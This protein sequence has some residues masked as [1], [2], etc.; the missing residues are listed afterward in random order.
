MLQARNAPGVALRTVLQ[1]ANGIISYVQDVRKSFLLFLYFP[2]HLV[3]V[4]GI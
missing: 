4:G 1:L 3:V 2:P